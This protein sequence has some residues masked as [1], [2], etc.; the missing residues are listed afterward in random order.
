M[1]DGRY[2]LRSNRGEC[3]IPIQL[4][5]VSHADFLTASGDGVNSSQSGQVFTDLS[6]SGS[7]I[8]ISGLLEHSDQTLS[9]IHTHS[10]SGV[11]ET[12]PGQASQ[13]SGSNRDP[14]DQNY[15]NT[16]ILAQLR[17]LGARLDSM[18]G[19]MKKSVKKTND[20]SKV[21]KSKQNKKMAMQKLKLRRW[22]WLSRLF[23]WHIF[24]HAVG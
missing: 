24:P 11:T 4:Q 10:Q 2:N 22:V 15:I 20:S 14:A 19:S 17:A 12:R 7:N 18:E 23:K 3:R 6:D 5:L 8:D 1:N 16:H 13:A 21:K 9:P